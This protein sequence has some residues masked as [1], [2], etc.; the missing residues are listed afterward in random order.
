MTIIMNGDNE[1]SASASSPVSI[2][3]P[4]V[5]NTN[6]SRPRVQLPDDEGE[7]S[8]Q[9]RKSIQTLVDLSPPV[10]NS[11]T[12]RDAISEVL[13]GYSGFPSQPIDN[14]ADSLLTLRPF[15]M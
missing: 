7:L 15:E 14:N 2:L 5:I 12:R 1:D 4:I 13:G 10:I 8:P 9:Q 6:Q 3:D 11:R